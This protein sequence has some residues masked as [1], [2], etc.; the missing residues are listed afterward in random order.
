MSMNLDSLLPE[1]GD[2]DELIQLLDLIAV[3]WHQNEASFEHRPLAVWPQWFED[4]GYRFEVLQAFALKLEATLIDPAGTSTISQ[5]IRSLGPNATVP[6][7]LDSFDDQSPHLLKAFEDVLQISQ[8]ADH[9]LDDVAGGTA[10]KW[11]KDHPWVDTAVVAGVAGVAGVTAI[12]IGTY[13]RIQRKKKELADQVRADAD[14]ARADVDS[15]TQTIEE[16]IES[17]E[18]KSSDGSITGSD[19]SSVMSGLDELNAKYER[20]LEEEAG[21]GFQR[22][23]SRAERSSS[24]EK[25]ESEAKSEVQSFSDELTQ[26]A[27]SEVYSVASEEEEILDT[28][29]IHALRTSLDKEIERMEDKM[30]HTAAEDLS[31]EIKRIKEDI[32]VIDNI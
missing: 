4:Q 27:K 6:Q 23:F 19:L 20:D 22:L 25:L 9:T 2:R 13:R 8:E 30:I 16:L 5:Q 14:R 3:Q 31:P 1:Q 10:G 12:G 32:E 15:R 21:N 28:T 26:R 17:V 7:L 11:M 18:R 24:A 29:I